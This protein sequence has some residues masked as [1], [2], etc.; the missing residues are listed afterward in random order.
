MGPELTGGS[1]VKTIERTYRI[2][3]REIAYL[4]FILEGYDNLAIM[5][6]LDSRA[7]LIALYIPP[8]FE[9]EVDEIMMD[10]SREIMIE[11]VN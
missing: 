8:G 3:R 10:L 9:S 4:K 11:P 6:T 7:G 2:D 1:E 5:T